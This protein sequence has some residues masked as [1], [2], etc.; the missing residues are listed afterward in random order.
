VTPQQKLDRLQK[1]GEALIAG[2][3]PPQTH[4][5]VHTMLRIIHGQETTEPATKEEQA[6]RFSGVVELFPNGPPRSR[7]G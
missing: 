4:L 5:V 3:L 1:F 2:P 6:S 7:K